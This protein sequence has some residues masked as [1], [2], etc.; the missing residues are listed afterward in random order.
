MSARLQCERRYSGTSCE[1]LLGS[2]GQAEK[3]AEDRGETPGLAGPVE[4]EEE[5]E[6]QEETGNGLLVRRACA[7]ILWCSLP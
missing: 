3:E 7:S 6:C 5:K 2:D 1:G 4:E